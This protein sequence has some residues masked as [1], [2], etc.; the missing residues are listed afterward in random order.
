M[1]ELKVERSEGGSGSTRRHAISKDGIGEEP[2]SWTPLAAYEAAMLC[3]IQATQSL[4]DLH[5]KDPNYDVTHQR[6]RIESFEKIL[7]KA[8][9]LVTAEAVQTHTSSPRLGELFTRSSPPSYEQAVSVASNA[10]PVGVRTLKEQEQIWRTWWRNLSEGQDS[11]TPKNRALEELCSEALYERKRPRM[12]MVEREMKQVEHYLEDVEELARKYL[13][14][15]DRTISS[16]DDRD[17]YHSNVRKRG[18]LQ[19]PVMA[20]SW[21]HNEAEPF[22]EAGSR[23][24]RCQG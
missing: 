10:H 8:Y 1:T 13:Q 7:T 21:R 23:S 20:E 4:A 2:R 9:S 19:D 24:G 11:R 15:I 17:E 12:I 14:D 5:R 6:K 3:C 16:R 18:S 22:E